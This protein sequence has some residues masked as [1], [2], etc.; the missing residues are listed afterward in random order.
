ME[1]GLMDAEVA[2]SG[3]LGDSVLGLSLPRLLQIL[4]IDSGGVRE[5]TLVLVA[6]RMLVELHRL[7]HLL[8]LH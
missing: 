1:C 7:C 5:M 2:G 4:A 6:I 8:G 3:W